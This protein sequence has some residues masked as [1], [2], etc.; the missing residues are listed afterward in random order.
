MDPDKVALFLDT[1]IF[2][3]RPE[4]CPFFRYDD[5]SAKGCCTVHLTRPEICRD[6]GCWR[7]LILDPAGNRAGRIMGSRHLAYEDAALGRLFEE[8]INYITGLSDTDWDEHVIRVLA[9]AGY[10][11]RT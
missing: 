3:Q 5:V 10:T 7:M 9:G 2:T 6:Y 1:R 11:V 8:K 4:A